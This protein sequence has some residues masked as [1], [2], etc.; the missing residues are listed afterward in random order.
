LGPRKPTAR[1]AVPCRKKPWPSQG[2][3]RAHPQTL[4]TGALK[5]QTI[6]GR[7]CCHLDQYRTWPVLSPSNQL[8][9]GLETHVGPGAGAKTINGLFSVPVSR[10]ASSAA[11]FFTDPEGEPGHAR[12]RKKHRGGGATRGGLAFSSA[13]HDL[14]GNFPRGRSGG[15]SRRQKKGGKNT[16]GGSGGGRRKPGTLAI[17]KTGGLPN[18]ISPWPKW[19]F[20]Y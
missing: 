2:V 13:P 19:G 3:R 8:A 18:P 20:F 12:G 17:K 5:K 15:G 7:L 16:P 14:G 10:L 9:A 11:A 6:G 1:R 4:F